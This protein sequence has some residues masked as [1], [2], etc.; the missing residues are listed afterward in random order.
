M[1]FHLCQRGV[2]V[3]VVAATLACEQSQHAVPT[4]TTEQQDPLPTQTDPVQVAMWLQ[5]HAVPIATAEVGGD[6]ADLQPFVD[7]PGS[8]RLERPPRAPTSCSR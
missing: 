7:A 1:P 4:N 3:A 5:Q 2:T 8:W 6:D